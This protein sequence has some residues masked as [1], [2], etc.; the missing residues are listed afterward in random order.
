MVLGSIGSFVALAAGVYRLTRLCFGPLVGGARGAADADAR[1]T[2][3]L[4]A[5]GYLDITYVALIVWAAALEVA[6]APPRAARLRAAGR[7]RAAAPRRVAAERGLLAVVRVAGAT[8]RRAGA[9]CCTL[10]LAAL[11][12]LLWVALDVARH[13]RP[14]VLAALHRRARRRTLGRTQGFGS[15]LGR[16]LALRGPDR[17]AAGRAGR[18]RGGRA[19]AVADAAPRAAS[20]W[21]C[22]RRLLAVYIADGRGRGVGD[23]PLPAGR[24]GAAAAL[25]RV[26]D[27]RLVAAERGVALRRVWM[28]AGARAACLYGALAAASVTSLT[29]IAHDAGLPRRLPRRRSQR[30]CTPRAVRADLRRCGPLSLPDHKLI[31]D[32]RWILDT[33][34]QHDIVARSEARA[35]AASGRPR[36]ASAARARQRRGLPARAP[37]SSARRSSTSA[38]TRSTRSPAGLRAR[39]TPASTTPSMHNC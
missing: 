21:R 13:R 36:A 12:P 39:S 27:R 11:A 24:R 22:W 9:G 38:T 10:A 15:V 28:A 8:T 6:A 20:R 2:A 29:S 23:R 25:L 16:D 7:R 4:A 31:P 34:G 17:Q 19:R 26:R 3:N 35:D 37:R 30:R 1:S 18:A 14:A 5:Q 33:V 32:A